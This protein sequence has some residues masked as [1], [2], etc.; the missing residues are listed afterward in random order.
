MLTAAYGVKQCGLLSVELVQVISE[1]C[2]LVYSYE[3]SIVPILGNLPPH[4]GSLSI[5]GMPEANG[6]DNQFQ[7]LS[8]FE[9]SA[10][11]SVVHPWCLQS[12]NG[13]L[14]LCLCIPHV[15]RWFWYAYS[16]HR[17]SIISS[18]IFYENY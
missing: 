4:R 2:P 13:G 15:L 7:V 9:V 14:R 11:L 8:G 6:V 16:T 17:G 12:R 3:R 10:G 5:D 1:G 18:N